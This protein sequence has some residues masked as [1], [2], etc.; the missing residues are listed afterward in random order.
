MSSTEFF[1]P[2]FSQ[3]VETSSTPLL[4]NPNNQYTG[5]QV[6]RFALSRTWF[7]LLKKLGGRSPNVL[8]Q[9]LIDFAYKKILIAMN[10]KTD[11]E[12]MQDMQD[13]VDAVDFARIK[14]VGLK[15][16]EGFYKK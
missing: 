8:D 15:P 3:S 1:I 13:I 2:A 14:I 4:V 5:V 10:Q 6:D 7:L 9:K 16:K 12:L 11:A